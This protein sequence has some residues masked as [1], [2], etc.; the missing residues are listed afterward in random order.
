MLG[1]SGNDA[2]RIMPHQNPKSIGALHIL[3]PQ[4]SAEILT[5]ANA[6]S[7]AAG[8][9]CYRPTCFDLFSE[10]RALFLHDDSGRVRRAVFGSCQVQGAVKL[11]K[12]MKFVGVVWC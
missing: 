7:E 12:L 2:Y 1:L 8:E 5:T 10:L 11:V 9:Y 4:I 3:G 6:E